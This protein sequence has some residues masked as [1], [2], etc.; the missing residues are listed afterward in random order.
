MG[1]GQF[2]TALSVRADRPPQRAPGPCAGH[3]RAA[4]GFEGSRIAAWEL[5]QAGV[6]HAVVTDAAAP[7]CIA[8]EEVE[9]V[10][11]GADRI[12]A[13]GDVIGTVGCYPLALAA[14]AA[15]V[16]FVVCATTNALDPS[17]AEGEAATIEEGRPA[18]VL[19]AGGHADGA[20]GDR[21]SGTRSRTSCP[22]PW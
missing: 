19:R 3:R 16:P 6:Q 4:P 18:L 11:A 17:V 2:G 15:G 14:H 7:G 1:G 9:V 20:R 13:N 12:A 21:R 22:R 8:A 10:L 5:R